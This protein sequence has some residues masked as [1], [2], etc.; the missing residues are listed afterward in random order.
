MD[1]VARGIAHLHQDFRP[2]YLRQSASITIPNSLSILA[3][4]LLAP[5]T[6]TLPFLDFMEVSFK[7]HNCCLAPFLVDV[8]SDFVGAINTVLRQH[9]SPYLLTP[10]EFEKL[11][12][13]KIG[14]AQSFSY[15]PI[16]HPRIYLSQ[17]DPIQTQAVEP[18]LLLLSAS[19]YSTPNSD[20]LK[21]LERHRS[22]DFA[23]VATSC[24]A[25]LEGIIDIVS[26]KRRLHISGNGLRRRANSFCSKMKPQLPSSTIDLIGFIA[27]TRNAQGDAHGNKTRDPI[28]EHHAKLLIGLTASLSLFLAADHRK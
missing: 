12:G 9:E 26:Q 6:K 5:K 14:E 24:A 7:P 22:G 16:T 20:F 11:L 23:G 25:V 4:Y 8:G 15:I 21:A 18:T 28:S 17:P 2:Q 27:A 10:L 19:V 1:G 3:N 13:P